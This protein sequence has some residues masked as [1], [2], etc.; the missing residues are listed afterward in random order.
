MDRDSI[1]ALVD[2]A[3]WEYGQPTMGTRTYAAITRMVIAGKTYDLSSLDAIITSNGKAMRVIR[4]SPVKLSDYI[5]KED[6]DNA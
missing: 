5:L 6:D 3:C 4:E 2:S 1:D